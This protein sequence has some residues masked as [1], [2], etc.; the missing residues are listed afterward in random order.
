MVGVS[1]PTDKS[2]GDGH[3]DGGESDVQLVEVKS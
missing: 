1:L 3:A 2:L